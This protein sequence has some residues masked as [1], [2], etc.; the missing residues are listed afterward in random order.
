M[1]RIIFAVLFLLS[2]WLMAMPAQCAD[3]YPRQWDQWAD[4]VTSNPEIAKLLIAIARHESG[5]GK[6]RRYIYDNNAFGLVSP[7][8]GKYMTFSKKKDSFVEAARRLHTS[9]HYALAILNIQVTGLTRPA[10]R[11]VAEKWCPYGV[12]HWEEIVWKL[13]Q[14]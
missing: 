1:K 11:L 13:V 9:D 8:T 12:G 2:L 5:N 6:S 7:N 10:V 4:E 3:I 14:A